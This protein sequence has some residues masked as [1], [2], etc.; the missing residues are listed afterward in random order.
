MAMSGSDGSPRY[1]VVAVGFHW[2][3]AACLAIA[4]GLGLTVA[5]LDRG[6]TQDRLFAIH[7][8][9]GLLI[10]MLVLARLA[11]RARHTPPA[12]PPMS[13]PQ[14]WLAR[15][16]HVLLYVITLVM[17]VS[18]YVAV[19]ARGRETVFFGLWQ[20]PRWVTPDRALAHSA[21]TIHGASQFVLYALVAA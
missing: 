8:S 1:G 3:V 19:A 7:K 21:E 2:S 13:R 4:V 14:Y 16:T 15:T 5:S 6:E 17:P 11:W 12:M 9:F 10:L 18:G 20:V